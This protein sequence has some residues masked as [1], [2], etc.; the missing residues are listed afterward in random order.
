ML[1]S[2]DQDGLRQINS[3]NILEYFGYFGLTGLDKKAMGWPW[4][5]HGAGYMLGIPGDFWMNLMEATESLMVVVQ[6][7]KVGISR[8]LW[9]AGDVH[10]GSW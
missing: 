2:V 3:E 5:G 6:Y 9:F 1:E 7:V 10:L 4:D 8:G